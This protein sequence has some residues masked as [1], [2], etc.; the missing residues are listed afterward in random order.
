[1]L[2]WQEA[3]SEI[4][5]PN[6]KVQ[7]LNDVLLSVFSNFIPN[8]QITAR[9]NQAPLGHSK[10]LS[11]LSI[12]K[13]R[14]FIKVSVF[15]L[16]PPSRYGYPSWMAPVRVICIGHKR[17]MISGKSLKRYKLDLFWTLEI[18]IKCTLQ[19]LLWIIEISL[20]YDAIVIYRLFCI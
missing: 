4:E 11:R 3:L 14:H 19:A 7:L 10:S 6:L 16:P 18:H 13:T 8:K 17:D 2:R 5:C 20:T 9:L 12:G 1:M 15:P